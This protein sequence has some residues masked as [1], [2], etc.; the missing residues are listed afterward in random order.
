M[1][2]RDT[3]HDPVKNALI[4]DGWTIIADPYRIT[5]K[6]ATLEADLKADKLIAATRENRSVV[7]EVKSF[8]KKSFIHEFIAA[9]GQ[10]HSYVTLL[11]A[12]NESEE[13]YMAVSDIIY[14]RQ[15]ERKSIQLLKQSFNLHLL[16]VDIE[17]EEIV[18]WID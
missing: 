8:L 6:D 5:Y 10:Y 2:R 16:V 18:K 7:I 17:K 4:K 12:N 1:G 11:R 3:I 13:I 9:C 15:F 14:N